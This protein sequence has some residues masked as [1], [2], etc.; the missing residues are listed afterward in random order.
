MWKWSSRNKVETWQ[1]WLFCR[2]MQWYFSLGCIYCLSKPVH[3]QCDSNYQLKVWGINCHF[4]SI[5]ATVLSRCLVHCSGDTLPSFICRPTIEP[6]SFS[7]TIAMIFHKSLISSF[8]L[9]LFFPKPTVVLPLCQVKSRVDL[10]INRSQVCK[11]QT[12]FI[13]PRLSKVFF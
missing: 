4:F 7:S 5:I 2:G 8:G 1:K 11:S 10:K 13:E 9:W 3:E 12:G 6:T